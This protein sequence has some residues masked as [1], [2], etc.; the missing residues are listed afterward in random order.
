MDYNKISITD[1]L[2]NIHLKYIHDFT[3]AE[4][5]AEIEITLD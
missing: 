1:F 2:N 4:T 3:D 5:D